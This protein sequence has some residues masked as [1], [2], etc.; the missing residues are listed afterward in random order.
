M[1]ETHRLKNVVIF[2]QTVLSFVLLK[3]S[4]KQLTKQKQV[5]FPLLRSFYAREKLLL[6]FF[7]ICLFLFF[8]LLFTCSA[9]FHAVKKF[10]KIKKMGRKLS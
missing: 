9:F 7:N 4:K 2:I 3:K 8:Y 1:I 6:W 10:K 5:T